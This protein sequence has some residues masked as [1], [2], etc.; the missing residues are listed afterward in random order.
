MLARAEW[1]KDYMTEALRAVIEFAFTLPKVRRV[2]A[3]CDVDNTASARVME[4]AGLER[5]GILR[6][7]AAHSNVSSEPRDVFCYSI[8]R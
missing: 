8:V 3:V 5:E 6:K 4:K 2:W 1:G 7:Y